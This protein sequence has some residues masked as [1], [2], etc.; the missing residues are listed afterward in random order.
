MH[1]LQILVLEYFAIY[2]AFVLVQRSSGCFYSK[3]EITSLAKSYLE[4]PN[5]LL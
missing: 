2:K 1:D 4:E 5:R 3:F